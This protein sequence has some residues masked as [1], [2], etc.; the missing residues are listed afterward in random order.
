VHEAKDVEQ[1]GPLHLVPSKNQL[2]LVPKQPIS[3]LKI[4]QLTNTVC[5]AIC[6]PNLSIVIL[7]GLALPW[8]ICI[9]DPALILSILLY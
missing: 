4:N 9:S 8:C 3:F 5:V 7:A 1:V 6:M 2:L